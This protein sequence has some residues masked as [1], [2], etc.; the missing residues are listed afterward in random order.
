[1]LRR[2]LE[3]E[4]YTSWAFG[5]RLREAGLL[6][7]MGSVG[8]CFDNSVAESFFATLQTELIKPRK[9]WRTVEEVELATAEWIDWFN[10]RRLYEYCGDVPPAELE[11]AHYAQQPAQPIAELSHR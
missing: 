5:H 2:P 9:P 8:D 7:S 10:H 3:P 4:Q 1:M 11:A 6:G